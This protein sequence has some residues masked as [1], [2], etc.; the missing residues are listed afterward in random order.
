MSTERGSP[1][2]PPQRLLLLLT[3]IFQITCTDRSRHAGEAGSG[4][5]DLKTERATKRAVAKELREAQPVRAAA[6]KDALIN[7]AIGTD[8][9]LQ[10]ILTTALWDARLEELEDACGLLEL[11]IPEAGWGVSRPLGVLVEH[12]GD[13]LGRLTTV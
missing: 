8:E 12:A 13:D 10:H 3:F 6:L 4:V 2:P 1:A 9:A 7:T 5:L 11:T